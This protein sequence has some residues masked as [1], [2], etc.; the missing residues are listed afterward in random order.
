MAEASGVCVTMI[1]I[2]DFN[3]HEV[4]QSSFRL[5]DHLFS[6]ISDESRKRSNQEV[7]FMAQD[8]VNGFRKLLILVNG[9]MQSD[10]L[11]P[12]VSFAN[13]FIHSL[14]NQ[15]M[16]WFCQIGSMFGYGR[17]SI[18]KKMILLSSSEILVTQD[19]PC[20]FPSKKKVGVECEEA[21]TKCAASTGGCH[22]SKRR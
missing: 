5:A 18:D 2:W 16:W 22:C 15:E 1:P 11:Y 7:S 17:N 9:S 6:C 19:E 20:M 4:A 13:Q 12:K 21:S 10:P 8:T 14:V 3:V